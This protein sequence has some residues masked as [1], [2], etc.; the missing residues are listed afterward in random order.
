M[1]DT[2]PLL[3]SRRF[4]PLFLAQWFGAFSDNALKSAFAFLVVYRGVDLF[5][6]PPELSITIGG[7]GVRVAVSAD[8]R[9]CRQAVGFG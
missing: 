2:K 1:T 6:L 8:F 7:G 3:R 5:G 9:H 4:L